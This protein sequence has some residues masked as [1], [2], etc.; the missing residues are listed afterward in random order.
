[1]SVTREQLRS[2]AAAFLREV[3]KVPFSE[4]EAWLRDRGEHRA[5]GRKRLTINELGASGA[6]PARACLPR[7]LMLIFAAVDSQP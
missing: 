5:R 2:Y 3:A 7:P 4:A 6:R 1:M